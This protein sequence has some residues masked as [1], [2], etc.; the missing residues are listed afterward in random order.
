MHRAGLRITAALG[1]IL[2]LSSCLPGA[3]AGP[4]GRAEQAILLVRADLSGT[5]VATVVVQVTA[6]DIATPLVF[7]IAVAGGVASGTIAVSTGSSRTITLR[8]YDAGGV[9][10]HTGSATVKI[11][12]GTNP[13]LSIVLT[14]LTG[15]LPITVT[16]GSFSVAV[17]PAAVAL[18]PGDTMTLTASVLDASGNPVTGPVSWATLAPAV[19]TVVTT[20]A[21]TGRLTAVG[22][23]L[24]IVVAAYSG[25]AGSAAITVAPPV[26]ALVASGLSTALYL[27]SPPG[28]T[29]RAFVVQQTGTIRVLRRDTLLTTP[30]LDLSGIIACCGEQGLLSMA[31]HPSYASNG[32]FYVDYTAPSGTLTI[33]RYHV[34]ADPNLADP[35]SGEILLTIPH[36]PYT[37]HNGGLVTFGPDGYLYIGTGDGGSNGDP[38]GHGQDSTVLLG[39]ILRIDVDRAFPYAIPPT[40]PFVGRAPA[41]PEV[42]AYGLRNPW[43]FSFDHV[44]GDFYIADVGQDLWEEIDFA[45]ARDAGG[46]N[47][48]WN[49]MEGLHCYSPASGCV[50]SGLVLPVYEYGHGSGC[51]I[52]GGYVYRGTRH[53]A[54]AGRYFF[55]DYC[56]GWVRSL[57]TRSGVATD[58]VD[59][60]AEFGLVPQITSFGEDGRG[61]L[62]ITLGNGQVYRITTR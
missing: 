27:T 43:R 31:F 6:P 42:W 34:S 13:T 17:Q 56:S 12:L 7:D 28:D 14:S 25:V 11:Q 35:V 23:G 41:A 60:T 61:E 29:L 10:T 54:L 37:N 4:D 3:P 45:Q 47:Y 9:E 20:G 1:S 8:A 2:A 59:Y 39:K 44:T 32:R 57:R 24:A 38:F 40:N 15:D 5:L 51:S 50:M 48:G 52:T 19:A 21:Q 26:L 49:T 36:S 55:A 18:A 53:P 46:H 30:F 62:Y 22:G 16:L 58:V 33:A